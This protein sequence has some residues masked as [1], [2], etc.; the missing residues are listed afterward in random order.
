M[1]SYYIIDKVVLAANSS[2]LSFTSIPATY[3]DLV[4]VI[5]GN[6]VSSGLQVALQFNT[7]TTTTHYTDTSITGTVSTV[8]GTG[9]G[10]GHSYTFL[11]YNPGTGPFL[12]VGNIMDYANTTTY[13]STMARYGAGTNATTQFSVGTYY[14]TSAISTIGITAYN[15]GSYAAGTT[16]TL[17][18][19]IA[20]GAP[21]ATGGTISTDGI[22]YYHTFGSTSAF[23]PN[24]SITA[25][26][27]TIAG[28]G[29]AGAYYGGGG[30]AGGV[31]YSSSQALTAI[32]YTITIGAGGTGAN[33]TSYGIGGNGVNSQFGALT[34]AVGGGGG[35]GGGS[36]TPGAG[37]NGGS[38]GG[39][40]GNSSGQLAGG[41]GSQ[42]YGGAVGVLSTSGGGGGGAGAA[43]SGINGGTGTSTYS[44]WGV[45]TK[46]GQL[47]SSTYYYAGGGASGPTVGTGGNGGGGATGSY[48]GTANTGSGG[49]A[50]N[51]NLVNSGAGGSGI[52]IVRYPVG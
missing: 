42:G 5:N 29:G 12:F 32:S 8:S 34:A 6:F 47:V 16:F 21:K 18:G 26:V 50:T 44:S 9:D 14:S 40:S 52:V 41:T 4:L 39:G 25:D 10:T 35:G 27:L 36:S 13:K 31:V 48:P 3:T 15:G 33:G 45:A 37:Q 19:I 17:Y 1:A 24:T 2:S 22:Y 11:G 51:T 23:V 30:G 28:G 46:T 43:G 7:D 49:G 38:G 20:N